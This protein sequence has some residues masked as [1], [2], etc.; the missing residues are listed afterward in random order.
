MPDFAKRSVA[1]ARGYIRKDKVRLANCGIV[2]C[3][4]VASCDWWIGVLVA[5][6]AVSVWPV[7][8]GMVVRDKKWAEV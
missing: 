6:S 8:T 5:N 1:V 3:D 2:V 4:Y 7:H